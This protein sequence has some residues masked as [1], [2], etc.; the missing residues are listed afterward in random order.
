[1]LNFLLDDLF[2][3]TISSVYGDRG[4]SKFRSISS[5]SISAAYFV[6]VSN[7]IKFSFS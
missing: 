4:L 2:S 1:M 7:S 6:F 3:K 5:S